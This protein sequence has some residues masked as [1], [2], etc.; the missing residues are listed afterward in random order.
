MLY[1]PKKKAVQVHN[2]WQKAENAVLSFQKLNTP[3]PHFQ[4]AVCHGFDLKH[5]AHFSKQ[6]SLTRP[7]WL[8]KCIPSSWHVV[9]LVAYYVVCD[10]VEWTVAEV[11]TSYVFSF[12]C[13]QG[14]LEIVRLLL[15]FK[16]NPE[17]ADN[18]GWA[19]YL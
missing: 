6:Q 10:E 16:V 14:H 2:K 17:C 5:F 13:S 3:I 9:S 15:E 4:I 11:T 1:L 18:D 12:S 19:T 7:I 8:L